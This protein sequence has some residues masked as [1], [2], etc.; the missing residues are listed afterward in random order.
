MF[1][2]IKLK[3]TVL[4]SHNKE[5]MKLKNDMKKKKKLEFQSAVQRDIQK[6]KIFFL[7]DQP[8]EKSHRYIK[9]EK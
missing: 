1:S 3:K 9:Q 5:N 8:R 6:R 4:R 2:L 7:L